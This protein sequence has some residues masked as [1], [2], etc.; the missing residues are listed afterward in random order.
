MRRALALA[1]ALGAL[2]L[3]DPALAETYRWTDKDG[4]V[5]FTDDPND[6]PEPMR[7]RVL[8]QLE[9]ERQKARK[10]G[11]APGAAPG[12]YDPL[13]PGARDER[14][15]PDPG[16]PPAVAS[17]VPPPPPQAA[18]AKAA[19]EAAAEAGAEGGAGDAPEAVQGERHW[20]DKLAA[21]RKRVTDL[22]KECAD[23]EQRQQTSRTQYLMFGQGA[24]QADAAEA[25]DLQQK[26]KT[27]LDAARRYLE[28]GLAEEARK[29]GASPGWVR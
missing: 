18:A 17:P 16:A 3:G 27:D 19:A 5:H 21:A 14:L 9:A 2:W 7:T 24:A 20:R 8:Q 29:A 6:L 10:P 15:P 25:L 11:G 1:T 12:R 26:C 28:S 4:T 22:E 23:L 13:P